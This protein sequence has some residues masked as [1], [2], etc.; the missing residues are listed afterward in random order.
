MQLI[1]SGGPRMAP[2]PAPAPAQ[3]ARVSPWRVL[4]G[5]FS[6][7]GD[8]TVSGALDRERARLQA[9]ADRPQMM[10]RQAQLRQ[11]AEAMGPAAMLAFDLNPEKFGENLSE[12]YAPQ[13]IGAGGV[14]S[15]IG[16][17]AR[18]SAPRDVEFG[19]SLVR[20]DPL[21][22]QPTMLATRGPT[23]QEGISQE[24]NAQKAADDAERRRLDALRLELDR[25][26]YG[27]D[28]EYRA[29][30][31]DLD[32][33]RLRNQQNAPLPG[34]NDDRAAIEGFRGSNARFA[35]QLRNIGGDPATGAPPAF[36]LSPFNAAR[37]KAAL[38]TGIGMTPEAAAYGDYVSEIEAAV[39]ESLRLN[40]GPQTDQ[41]AIREARALLSNIDNR[42]Y[43]MRR[44]PTVM[45]N[46]DR[47]REGRERLLR[48]RR[49]NG[50]AAPAGGGQPAPAAPNSAGPVRI[51]NDADYARLP[52]GALFAGPDGVTR[53]KP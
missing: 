37:Y 5:I 46:N 40:V 52:S 14:Q 30:L 32:R 24:S 29:A 21:N 7:E 8:G 26:K 44:L 47:L 41:D 28:E 35:T 4:D 12:Q 33:E 16:T 49:P 2:A 36:D 27:S 42:E 13:V 9:E 43:V 53:R 23:I 50:G 1:Q 45:A 51:Q 31:L 22:P 6:S 34:D 19:D 20:L 25:D 18:V 17:G 48:E 10:A 11:A 38:A 3:R 15:L 39:S